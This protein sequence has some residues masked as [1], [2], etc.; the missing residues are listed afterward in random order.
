MAIG[1]DSVSWARSAP[2]N[3]DRATNPTDLETKV[4]IRAVV[5][6]LLRYGEGDSIW[7]LSQRRGR[8][9]SLGSRDDSFT[10][11]MISKRGNA[12]RA[13]TNMSIA[14]FKTQIIAP[15]WLVSIIV[16]GWTC[17]GG[18]DVRRQ[19]ARRM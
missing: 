1:F 10:R 15:V 9:R 3:S 6:G 4:E 11:S 19:R 7:L 2:V 14:L 16:F 18:R 17:L 8:G 12:F 13:S 5:S